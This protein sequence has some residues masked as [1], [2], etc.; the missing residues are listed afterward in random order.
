MKITENP[1]FAAFI[2]FQAGSID[3]FC[4]SKNKSFKLSFIRELEIVMFSNFI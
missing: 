3:Y 4:T 1:K 2:F